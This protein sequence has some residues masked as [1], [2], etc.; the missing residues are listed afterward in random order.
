M[1][2]P[3]LW[4]AHLCA[5]ASVENDERR[6]FALE[7]FGDAPAL[8]I[9]VSSETFEYLQEGKRR[10][11]LTVALRASDQ[12]CCTAVFILQ[13]SVLQLRCVVSLG[14]AVFAELLEHAQSAGCVNILLESED[15]ESAV[16]FQPPFDE[17][18]VE[19]LLEAVRGQT[20]TDLERLIAD[21]A[22]TGAD[23]RELNELPSAFPD[24]AVERV[25]VSVAPLQV[26]AV[27][28]G[29]DGLTR[30]PRMSALPGAEVVEEG[31]RFSVH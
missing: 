25:E 27:S 4:R 26:Q 17:W 14:H 29:G 16:A 8:V 28:S 6:S 31:K 30:A 3:P 23:C 19:M 7:A 18:D 12:E 22:I 24:V 11:M 21:A 5:S 20:G 9:S 13:F 2:R 10:G 1:K 15:G